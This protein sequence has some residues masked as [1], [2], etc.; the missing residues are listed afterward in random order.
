MGGF[1]FYKNGMPQY[2]LSRYDVIVLVYSGQLVPPTDEEIR[3]WSQSDGLSKTLA[4]VQTLWFVVQA[5]ARRVEGLPITQLE[6]MTLA[7]T[8]ITVAMYVTWWDKPKNVSGPFRIAVKELPELVSVDEW[9]WY[10]HIFYLIAG[11]HDRSITLRK[12]R[13]VPTFYGGGIL[14]GDANTFGAD[15]IALIAAMVFGAVHCAAWHY[16][17]P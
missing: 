7:Y 16:V 8:S 4:V 11:W 10:R 2:P 1:H 9:T 14:G 15:V 17:F 3:N 12:E 5:I 6:I 13:R